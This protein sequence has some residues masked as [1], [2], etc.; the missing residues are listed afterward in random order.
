MLE[1]DSKLVEEAV[2][3][4]TN[5][6]GESWDV[7]GV[8]LDAVGEEQRNLLS[9]DALATEKV[10]LG[11]FDGGGEALL[12]NELIVFT[13]CDAQQNGSVCWQDLQAPE[14]D[15]FSQ[16]V[17]LWVCAIIDNISHHDH[18]VVWVCFSIYIQE[19]PK[20]EAE[21]DSVVAQTRG[22]DDGL[23]ERVSGIHK[24]IGESSTVLVSGSTLNEVTVSEHHL[25]LSDGSSILVMGVDQSKIKS[26]LG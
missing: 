25:L 17:V 6:I 18:C 22:D 20:V 11:P 12:E 10:L 23:H 4:R 7:S 13:D 21:T 3:D 8:V 1:A 14:L 19:V 26:L 16:K 9:L 24:H 15:E 5:H 2:L